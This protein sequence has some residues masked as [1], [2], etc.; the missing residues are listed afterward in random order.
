MSVD[1][2]MFVRIQVGNVAME[3][4]VRIDVNARTVQVKTEIFFQQTGHI[5]VLVIFLFAGRKTDMPKSFKSLFTK[6]I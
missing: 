6:G 4:L 5:S 2:E 1:N 3:N